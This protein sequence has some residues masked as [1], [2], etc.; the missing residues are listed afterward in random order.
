MKPTREI[1]ITILMLSMVATLCYSQPVQCK[2]NCG[3]ET[4]GTNSDPISIHFPP[5]GN[6]AQSIVEFRWDPKENASE[7]TVEILERQSNGSNSVVH[8]MT[9]TN[10]AVLLNLPAMELTLEKMYVIVVKSNNNKRSNDATFILKNP[11]AR[12]EAYLSVRNDNRY[13]LMRGV[14]RSLLSTELMREQNWNYDA[15]KGYNFEVDNLVDMMKV[16]QHFNDYVDGLFPQGADGC[17]GN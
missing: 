9:T 14:N 15:L 11:I 1:F 17:A 5:C 8:T 12:E 10:T 6:L 13:Q 3:G 7:Y 16:H 2:R 4:G